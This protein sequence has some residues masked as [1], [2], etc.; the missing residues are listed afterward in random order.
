MADANIS[1][2]RYTVA[3]ILAMLQDSETV[4]DITVVPESEMYAHDT[5]C[6]SDQSDDEATGYH[7][8]LPS[9]LLKTPQTFKKTPRGDAEYLVEAEKLIVKWN[10]NSMVSNME[11]EFTKTEAKGWIKQKLTMDKVRQPKCIQDYNTHMGGMDLHDQFVSCYR[12]NI[13]SKKWWWPCFSWAPNSAMVN[14]WCYHMYTGL[15][16]EREK[17]KFDSIYEDTVRKVG[18]PSGRR[19]RRVGDVCAAYQQLQSETLDN[20]LNQLRNRFKDHEKLMF[21]ALLDPKKIA[22]YTE[23]FLTLK[24]LTESM[25]QLYHLT[26]VVLTITVSTS[27]VERSFSALKRIKTHARNSTGQ[28][29]LGALVL[30]STEKGLLSELKSK[31]KLYDTAIAHSIKKDQ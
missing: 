27:S 14:S 26:C 1:G 19:A 12:V 23:N 10:D 29:C 2:N 28:D 4:A 22:S 5:D 17:A 9:R 3:E 13:P 24:G 30:M 20:I 7:N 15:T 11:K 6:D 16:T 18:G 25:P 8:C 21:L 31:D